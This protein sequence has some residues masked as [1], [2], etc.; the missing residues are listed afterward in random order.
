M[1]AMAGISKADEQ[2]PFLGEVSRGPVNVRAGAN[3]NFEVVDKLSQGAEVVV[4]G[5]SY[6]WYKVQLPSTASGFIRADYIKASGKTGVVSGNK[7]NIRAKADSES[8]ILGQVH[9]GEQVKLIAQANGW[10]K[11]EPPAQATGWVHQDFLRMKSA[12]VPPQMLRKAVIVDVPPGPAGQ[13]P[14]VSQ[15]VAVQGRLMPL[16]Q[17]PTADVH[18]Q[19]VVNGKPAYYLQ[20]APHLEDFSEAFVR[21]EGD[22]MAGAK[23]PCPVVNLKKVLLVL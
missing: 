10:W 5:K 1:L 2:F 6:E 23:S 17:A 14:A 21:I 22:T 12:Q 15:A 11:L 8:A 4:L 9:K 19:V 18:Y 16:S 3:I 20:D 13:A 7:V